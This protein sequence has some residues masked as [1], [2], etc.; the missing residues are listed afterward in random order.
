MNLHC[1]VIIIQS[2]QF[3]LGFA[4]ATGHFMDLDELMTH[5][6]TGVIGRC[7]CEQGHSLLP[8]QD[9]PLL[10]SNPLFLSSSLGF[11]VHLRLLFSR[12]QTLIS[13]VGLPGTRQKPSSEYACHGWRERG[14]LVPWVLMPSH[15]RDLE[16]SRWKFS[17]GR[18]LIT[19]YYILR[20]N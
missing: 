17:L 5:T 16:R 2:P 9:F 4:L 3:T 12:I 8:F 18:V 20:N 1:H 15:D 7:H 10:S 6:Y 19:G 13:G 11:W 14:S